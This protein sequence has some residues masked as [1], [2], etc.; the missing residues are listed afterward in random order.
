LFQ[1]ELARKIREA[2]KPR[3]VAIGAGPSTTKTEKLKTVDQVRAAS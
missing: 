3:R 2:M 1:I